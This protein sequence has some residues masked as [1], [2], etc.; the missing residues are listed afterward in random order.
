VRL[1]PPYRVPYRFQPFRV[2]NMRGVCDEG[3][4]LPISRCRPSIPLAFEPFVEDE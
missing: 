1:L 4:R 2:L 3:G